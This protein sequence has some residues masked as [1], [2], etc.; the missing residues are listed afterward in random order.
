MEGDGII[1]TIVTTGLAK[2][3]AASA[4]AT[5]IATELGAPFVPR[6]GTG[7]LRLLRRHEADVALIVQA[8]RLL[9]SDGTVEYSYHPNML[10]VRGLNIL[11]NWRDLFF[12][13]AEMSEGESVLDCTLG[14]GCEAS[15]AALAVGETGRVVGLESNPAL[16]V[17]TREGLREFHLDTKPLAA[18]MRRVAVVHADYQTYLP[19]LAPGAFDLIAFDPFFDER[20]EGSEHTV[21]PLARFGDQRPLDPASVLLARQIATRR[22]VVKHPSHVE[23]PAEL[24]AVRTKEMSARKGQ[25]AYSVFDVPS[26]EP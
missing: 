7:I 14:F 4:R 18:A 13:A 5:E 11:R 17:V 10:L 21:G 3:E 20:L 24:V 15:L 6:D 23:L 19:G 22:V 9:L 1:S 16:A 26:R 12:D 8:G 2:N 25:T